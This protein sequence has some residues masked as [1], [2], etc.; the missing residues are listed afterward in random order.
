MSKVKIHI[1]L[2]NKEIKEDY[3]IIGIYDRT[4]KI[5]KWQH[6]DFNQNTLYLFDWKTKCL[7]RE[8]K[9]IKMILTFIEKQDKITNC[10][11]KEFDHSVPLTLQIEQLQ[12]DAKSFSV[13]YDQKILDQFDEANEFAIKFQEI[14]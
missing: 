6:L 2:K 9:E 4:Q 12:E 7:I 3:E 14:E 13:I 11:F 1:H 5:L 8:N 10:K